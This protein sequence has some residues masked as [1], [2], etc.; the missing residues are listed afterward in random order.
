MR[1]QV[2][3]QRV[4][5]GV[6][7]GFVVMPGRGGAVAREEGRAIG[8]VREQAVDIGATDA[9]IG[10]NCAIQPAIGEAQH[11]AGGIRPQGLTHMHFVATKWRVRFGQRDSEDLAE[12]L[13]RPQHRFYVQQT[14]TGHPARGTLDAVGVGNAA[15]EHLVAAA[16]AEDAAAAPA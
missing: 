4:K 5:R 1:L 9:A 16:Q 6:D 10:G 12:L 13:G 2:R 11:W 7:P 15:P 8:V 3:A 14:E